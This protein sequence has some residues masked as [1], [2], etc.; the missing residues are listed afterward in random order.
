MNPRRLFWC[1]DAQFDFVM[2]D[3]KL[4]VKDAEKT[5]PVLE[6]VTNK[7]KE[8]NIAVITTGDAHTWASKEVSTNPDFKTTYP[9]HCERDTVGASFVEQAAPREFILVD[10][11]P[12]IPIEPGAVN[13][14]SRSG[15][16]NIDL[17]F[18]KNNELVSG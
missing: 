1:V 9:M 18:D 7:A 16:V 13:V 10:F 14:P 12:L 5:L 15:S 17:K 6:H 4:Y 2:P 8:E 11:L 3:G